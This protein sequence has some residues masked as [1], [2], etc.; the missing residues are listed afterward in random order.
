MT[1]H[2][3]PKIVVLEVNF[4]NILVMYWAFT[5]FLSNKIPKSSD[6]A[7]GAPKTPNWWGRGLTTPIP[8]FWPRVLTG[9]NYAHCFFW[10]IKYRGQIHWQQHHNS[11]HHSLKMAQKNSILHAFSKTIPDNT[12]P[13]DSI[14]EGSTPSH[15][16]VGINVLFDA[17]KLI[18]GRLYRSNDPNNS[19]P[20]HSSNPKQLASTALSY[21]WRLCPRPS[22]NN[23]PQYWKTVGTPSGQCLQIK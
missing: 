16:I 10:Q 9:Q 20:S 1:P 13:S 18:S 3:W 12:P 15:S 8:C 23:L 19:A 2:W 17:L 11:P 7:Y 4:S 6:R 14:Y 5:R 22:T 21:A